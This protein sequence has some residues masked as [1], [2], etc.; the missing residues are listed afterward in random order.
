MIDIET[1]RDTRTGTRFDRAVALLLGLIAVL[2]ASLGYVQM[3]AS[4]RESRATAEAARLTAVLAAGLPVRGVVDTFAA[5]ALLSA[6][7]ELIEGTASQIVG[8]QDGDDELVAQGV[9]RQQAGERLMTIATAMGTLPTGDS[10]L[11]GY[12]QGLVVADEPVL[13]A[14]LAEQNRL[15][16]DVIPEASTDSGRSVA[17]LSVLAF[18]GVLVGL[19]SV[20]GPTRAGRATL[21]VAW[22]ASGVATVALLWSAL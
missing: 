15:V 3:D 20:L 5:Q 18:A 2:A 14:Q 13:L 6:A 4:M 10:G 8:L 21:V 16:D 12:E 11:P 17:G 22:L 7:A 9:A 1:L 19:A